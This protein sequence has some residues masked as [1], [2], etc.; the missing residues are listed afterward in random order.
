M[1]KSTNEKKVQLNKDQ[2]VRSAINLLQKDGIHGLSM[3]KL[4]DALG[5]K[6][7]S[8]YWHVKNKSDLLQLIAEKITSE[9]DLPSSGSWDEQLKQ[10]AVQY[11]KVLHSIRDSAEIMEDT[12]PLTPQRIRLIEHVYQQLLAAGF[13][14]QSVPYIASL[15]NNFI[16]SFVQDEIRVSNHLEEDENPF[17]SIDIERYSLFMDV[18]RSVGKENTEVQFQFG[19]DVFLEGLKAKRREVSDT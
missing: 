8:L 6:A 17:S 3:R 1:T 2:I 9:V 10:I 16:L 18:N 13:P 5:V 7:A 12:V 4:A 14:K 11:R 19:L 15:Y